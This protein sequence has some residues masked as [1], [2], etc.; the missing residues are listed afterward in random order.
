MRC[1]KCGTEFESKFCPN[2]G[3]PAI[4]AEQEVESH[5]YLDYSSFSHQGL[6][7]QLVY[8]GFSQEQAEYGASA[9]GL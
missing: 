1:K 6:V 8:E 2:C 5:G 7:E 3:E 4:F 9:T